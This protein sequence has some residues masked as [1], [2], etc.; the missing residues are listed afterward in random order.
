MSTPHA[1]DALS[2]PTR[3]Q[4]LVILRGGEKSA[5]EIGACFD[6]SGASISHHLSLL[7]GADLVERR[8]VGQKVL[9]SLNTTVLQDLVAWILNLGQPEKNERPLSRS[10][11]PKRPVIKRSPKTKSKRGPS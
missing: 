7:H 3:R 8:K 5:G 1:L 9:Y 4:I 11:P 6:I 2:D 10:A